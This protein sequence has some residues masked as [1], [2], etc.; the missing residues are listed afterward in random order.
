[1]SK[2]SKSARDNRANQLNPTHR[3]YHRSRG[4]STTGAQDQASRSKPVLDNRSVQLNL[5]QPPRTDSQAK[6]KS[7]E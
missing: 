3:A 6:P 5:K 4:A 7:I 2:F 1:M